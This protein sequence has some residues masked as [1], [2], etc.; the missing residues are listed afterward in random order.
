[1][2]AR[3]R[4]WVAGGGSWLL[5]PFRARVG[6]PGVIYAAAE[7]DAIERCSRVK[8]VIW[9]LP[10]TERVTADFAFSQDFLFSGFWK[11]RLAQLV[12]PAPASSCALG[13]AVRAGQTWFRR[14]G[15]RD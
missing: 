5:S 10:R 6:H 4:P 14:S 7:K 3:A 13:A 15:R 12:H 2:G 8:S 11:L 9:W 1:M